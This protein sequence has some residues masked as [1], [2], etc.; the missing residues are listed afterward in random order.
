MDK[1]TSVP[2]STGFQLLGTDIGEKIHHQR[3]A[4]EW[5]S[6]ANED[7]LKQVEE[8]KTQWQSLQ[9]VLNEVSD[10]RATEQVIH[11]LIAAEKRYDYLLQLVKEAQ[12]HIYTIELR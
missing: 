10:P 5:A 11:Q 3:Q 8:A 6:S 12:M 1:S 7:L 2:Q 4:K 9:T